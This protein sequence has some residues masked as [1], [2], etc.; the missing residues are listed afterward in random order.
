MAMKKYRIILHC[1]ATAADVDYSEQALGRDHLADKINAP[2][3][4]HFYIR[5]DGRIVTGRALSRKGAHAQP[6]NKDSWGICYEGGLK[7]GG[8]TWRDAEDT[9]TNE[10]KAAILDCIYEVIA[11][12]RQTYA[13]LEQGVDYQIEIIGHG[14]LEGIRKECPCFDARKEYG[15]ITA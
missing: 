1:S 15:W 6:Y 10:Q 3:G 7:A 14:Q 9:R 13:T 8:K 4:Y 12:I 11:Y 2:M 5:K